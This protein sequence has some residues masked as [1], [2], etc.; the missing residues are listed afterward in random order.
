MSSSSARRPLE[1]LPLKACDFASACLT[2]HVRRDSLLLVLVRVLASA[3]GGDGELDVRRCRTLALLVD[4]RDSVAHV[5]AS[6]REAVRSSRGAYGEPASAS[7]DAQLLTRVHRS[8]VALDGAPTSALTLADACSFTGPLR[9]ACKPS[10]A[11]DAYRRHTS[12]PTR[13]CL[14]TIVAAYTRQRRHVERARGG[15]S[16]GASAVDALIARYMDGLARLGVGRPTTTVPDKCACSG[17]AAECSCFMARAIYRAGSRWLLLYALL[18]PV[19][20]QSEPTPIAAALP[21]WLE[22]LVDASASESEG[23]PNP[24]GAL[25]LAPTHSA[26]LLAALGMPSAVEFGAAT[27]CARLRLHEAERLGTDSDDGSA[28]AEGGDETPQPPPQATVHVLAA[29]LVYVVA[30]EP[31]TRY[32]ATLAAAAK[33]LDAYHRVALEHVLCTFSGTE[34]FARALALAARAAEQPAMAGDVLLAR[35]RGAR[36]LGDAVSALAH[37]LVIAAR[38]N[39]AGTLAL[40]GD[41]S[42]ATTAAAQSEYAGLACVLVAALLSALAA[43]TEPPPSRLVN[44][45][46]AE[47]AYCANIEAAVA[48]ATTTHCRR[49]PPSS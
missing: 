10:G 26:A 31:P 49:A 47:Y 4:A 45:Y 3:G 29:A 39:A 43:T 24:Y 21:P 30:T 11:L 22:R 6:V 28:S 25:A 7:A 46:A 13:L 27:R 44:T 40:N 33:H 2:A 23:A 8:V 15:G 5:C 9:D 1:S 14:R 35:V 37:P 48:R 36:T 18:P 20:T 32:T 16:S 17:N 12:A 41:G 38:T 19:R 34:L 42:A